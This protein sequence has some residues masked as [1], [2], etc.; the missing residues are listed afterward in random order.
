MNKYS[1]YTP[2]ALADEIVKLLPRKKYKSVI[3]ICCGTWNLLTA[4]KMRYPEADF[5]GVDIDESIKKYAF[6]GAK[7]VLDDGRAFSDRE[8]KAGRT[9]DLIL[10]NPPFGNLDDCEIYWEKEQDV[11]A[12]PALKCKRYEAEMMLANL[13]LTHQKSVV[14]FILP[15]TFVTGVTYK[16][17]RKQIAQAF[18]VRDIIELPID[19]FKGSKLKTVA[20]ILEKMD[21]PKKKANY[22]RATLNDDKW[23]VDQVRYISQ[24]EIKA[25]NWGTNEGRKSGIKIKRGTIHSGD[26]NKGNNAV[27]HC[28]SVYENGRWIPSLRFTEKE[29]NITAEYGDILINRIGRGAGYWCINDIPNVAISDCIYVLKDNH[30][31]VIRKL[32][33]NTIN[34]KL[35]VN[36]RGVSTRYI[37]Q[38]DIYNIIDS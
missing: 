28:S 10:S 15:V 30:Q 36:M 25:G 24:K 37:T 33:N 11:Y 34:G 8:M 12:Y 3:D 26:M 18:A 9:Y 27:L 4:A 21:R 6:E 38:D 32:N 17:A 16:K 13:Y 7:F 23:G 20:I 1:Y 31:D 5:Y 22:R 19:T 2:K 29:S 14:V 35:N